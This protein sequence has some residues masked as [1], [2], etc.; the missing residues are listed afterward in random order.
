MNKPVELPSGKIFNLARF[1]ALIPN[2]NASNIDYD[3][4]LEGYPSPISLEML[5]ANALKKI[6]KLEKNKITTPEESVWDREEQLQKNQ[7][8]IAILAER[9]KRHQ[10]MS[11]EESKERKE[12]FEGFKQIIDA[13][14]SPGQ[15]LYP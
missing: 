11:E 13:E 15:K 8:A 10:N 9:I 14:R 3:L 4:I 12:F 7:K 2:T 1:I 5:D 6:L